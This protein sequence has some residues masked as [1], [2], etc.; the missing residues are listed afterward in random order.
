MAR[1]NPGVRFCAAHFCGFNQ[2]TFDEVASFDNIWVDSAALS[3]G[4]DL[5][6][7]K[8]R[9]YESGSARISTDYRNPAQVFATIARRYPD[10]FMWG[11][12]NPAH[13]YVSH[14]PIKPNGPPVHL[15]L[16]SSMKREKAL[17]S[18]VRGRLRHQ[19]TVANAL[20]FIEG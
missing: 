10:K 13:S 17:L 7:K 12:D 14:A 9:I 1:E 18:Q 5:V 20:N 11:T 15:E 3:I 19:V 6:R 16:W 2:P 8:S 4:C